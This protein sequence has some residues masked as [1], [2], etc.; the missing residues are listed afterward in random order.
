MRF[1]ADGDDDRWQQ[2]DLNLLYGWEFN[3][4]SMFYVAYNQALQRWNGESESLDP[5][6]VAKVSYLLS[7]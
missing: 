1:A 5:V 6:V 2:Y 7:L 4:G 3:P